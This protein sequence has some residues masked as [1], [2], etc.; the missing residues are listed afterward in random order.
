MRRDGSAS[1][2]AGND[3]SPSTSLSTTAAKAESS[4][5][6]TLARTG[7]RIIRQ[8]KPQ[9]LTRQHLAVNR[10]NLLR[11]QATCWCANNCAE[12]RY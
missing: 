11:R 5:Y 4:G 1:I 3:V 10:L 9:R 2:R 8:Q 7:A 6:K 12:L